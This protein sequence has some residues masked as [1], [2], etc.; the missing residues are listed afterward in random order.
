MHK[1]IVF[2]KQGNSSVYEEA[3]E[4]SLIGLNN[5]ILKI[6]TEAERIFVPKENIEFWTVGNEKGCK[7]ENIKENDYG[8]AECADC[9][10]DLDHWYCPDSPDNR[11]HYEKFTMDQ[12]D[13]C[14]MPEERQ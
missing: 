2:W 13:Y 1:I 9:D 11:C 12:C 14:G 6:E 10:A 3:I 4:S 5:D 8:G 7:H